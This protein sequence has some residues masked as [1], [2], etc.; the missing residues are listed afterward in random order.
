ME[1]VLAIHYID[2]DSSIGSFKVPFAVVTKS[3]AAVMSIVEALQTKQRR[4]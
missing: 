1:L 2:L 4:K 3:M